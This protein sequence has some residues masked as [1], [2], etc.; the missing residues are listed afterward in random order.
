MRTLDQGTVTALADRPRRWVPVEAQVRQVR[1]EALQVVVVQAA[2]AE[3]DPAVAP[4][5][6]Q[7]VRVQEVIAPTSFLP[8]MQQTGR[9]A[10]V[11]VGPLKRLSAMRIGWLKGTTAKGGAIKAAGAVVRSRSSW[12]RR[13]VASSSG[14][15]LRGSSTLRRQGTL[16][17]SQGTAA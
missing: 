9:R 13:T 8:R 17:S 1:A 2:A 4:G 6:V 16:A 5:W 10:P 11:K 15:I 12:R 3:Q 14:P 7:G